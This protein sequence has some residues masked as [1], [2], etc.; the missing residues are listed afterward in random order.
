MRLS[1]PWIIGWGRVERF[2]PGRALA[3]DFPLE[4][5][6]KAFISISDAS[7]MY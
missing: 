3:F 5:A 7:E 4:K 6:E 1:L 2:S